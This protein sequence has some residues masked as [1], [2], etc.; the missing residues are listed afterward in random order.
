MMQGRMT[1]TP[2]TNV[3]KCKM[4]FQ[5][6]QRKPDSLSDC[7]FTCTTK[8]FRVNLPASIVSNSILFEARSS[9]PEF[10]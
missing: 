1:V 6:T 4:S 7:W 8:L 5:Q 3:Q 10:Q 2:I 9:S